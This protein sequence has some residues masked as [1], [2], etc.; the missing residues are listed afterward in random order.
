ML[1]VSAVSVDTL[2]IMAAEAL[3]IM[4]A[5]KAAEALAIMAVEAQMKHAEAL[6]I[7]LA[8]PLRSPW[9]PSEDSV[10]TPGRRQTLAQQAPAHLLVCSQV[11]HPVVLAH[12]VEG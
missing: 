7:V 2:A 11:G 5:A 12:F 6:A 4:A 10:R 3:A 1:P 8:A 9:A